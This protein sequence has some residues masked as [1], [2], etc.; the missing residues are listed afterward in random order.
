MGYNPR[1]DRL[2]KK[3]FVLFCIDLNRFLLIKNCNYFEKKSN[4]NIYFVC[5][6]E[7]PSRNQ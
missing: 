4:F 6:K 5:N 1:H 3:I 2:N 7:K